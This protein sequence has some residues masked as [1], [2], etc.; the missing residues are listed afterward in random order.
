MFTKF[1]IKKINLLALCPLFLL[2]CGGSSDTSP[3]AEADNNP[4]PAQCSR[5]DIGSELNAI[6]STIETDTDFSFYV[7]NSFGNAYSFNRGSSTLDT[8]YKSASTSK[9]VSA[10]AILRLVESGAL[11]LSDN[12]QA[13]LSPAQWP[14]K[15]GD[16]LYNITLSSLLS[17]TSGLINDDF[18]SNLASAD[19]FE[20]VKN[21][22]D[23]NAD[24]TEIPGE[25]FYYGSNHLQ[26]AGAMAIAAGGYSDWEALFDEFKTQTG[27]F[28]S[29][30]YNLPSSNNPRLAGGMTWTG[31]DYINFIRSYKNA[32]IFSSTQIFSTA[33]SDQVST[34][35]IENSPALSGIEE[36]WHYGYGLWIECHMSSFD[37]SVC[38]PTKSVSSPGA[39]GAYPFL[40]IEKDYFGIIARQGNLG[41]FRNGYQL[42]DSIS[43]K[44]E[45]WASCANN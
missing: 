8:P 24:N 5:N 9:W 19:F 37:S 16:S 18:C 29:S 26:V 21:I 3:N 4:P 23:K 11:Q 44:I 41:T 36:D 15:P 42:F 17:F 22:A 31:N 13:H 12:P 10:A 35:S 30:V 7:E 25:Q 40:N 20:C 34:A 43:S 45:E 38:T 2:G 6:L 14:I 33:T 27:L 1:H 39:Y 32:Y 28:G